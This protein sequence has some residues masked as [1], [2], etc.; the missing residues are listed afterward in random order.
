MALAAAAERGSEHAL[1][2]AIVGEAVAVRGLV[3]PPASAF[4]ATPGGGISAIV[5][6]VAVTMGRAGYVDDAGAGIAGLRD[7]AEAMAANGQTSVFVALDGHPA[8]VI[9][10][11]DTLRQ[12]A[13]EA[14]RDLRRLG[15]EVVMLTGDRPE[16]AAAIARQAGIDRVLADIRPEGK[17]LA[18]R[19]LGAGG[20]QVA[21]VGDGVND[22]PALAS[23][24]V[25]IAM[26]SGTD[27][28]MDAAGVTLMTG[29]LRAIVTAIGLSRATMRNIRQNLFWAFAYNV[30]L[31]PVAA[32]ALFPFTGML[33][34]PIL[35]AA[36]MAL[37]S[38]TVVSNALRLR[39]FRVPRHAG[40]ASGSPIVAPSSAG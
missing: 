19:E 2:G 34:D 29:D 26:G 13:A 28:A 22:A 10:V 39:G 25:G 27:I 35:A 32:G 15:L 17:A 33:L 23:A 6:G 8:A 30:V 24:S 4:E 3:L 40:T 12:G 5:D 14:V 9:G 37:S 20:T 21:M 38:V 18:I 1:A 16:T 36:A 11:A 7:V 31:I